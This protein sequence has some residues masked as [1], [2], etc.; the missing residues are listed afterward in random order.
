[1][2]FENLVFSPYFISFVVSLFFA[3]V[4]FLLNKKLEFS[5]NNVIFK[6]IFIFLCLSLGFR[7]GTGF[8]LENEQLSNVLDNLFFLLC[9][10][11]SMLFVSLICLKYLGKFNDKDSLFVA[12]TIGS[13]SF[14]LFALTVA[15]LD[16]NGLFF[17]ANIILLAV[18]VEIPIVILCYF[19]LKFYLKSKIINSKD[20]SKAVSSVIVNGAFVYVLAG[21][22]IS[23]ISKNNYF[24]DINYYFIS[25]FSFALTLFYGVIGIWFAKIIADL[26]R[27]NLKFFI[28]CTF[29]SILSAMAIFALCLYFTV[30]YFI[31]TF[32]LMVIVSSSSMFAVPLATKILLP[33]ADMDKTLYANNL[34]LFPVNIVLI[35]FYF[36]F[37]ES[38]LVKYLDFKI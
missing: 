11:V 35:H 16:S 15:L 13:S 9:V 6:S 30:P 25:P 29:F 31:D 24:E 17:S 36:Y 22:L 18:F 7:A 20:L 19:I 33:S 5:S 12:T 21:F 37:A 23:I 38:Y 2:S 1:M 34:L 3:L 14:V 10:Q 28:F 26:K 32:L 8:V 27:I 4:V